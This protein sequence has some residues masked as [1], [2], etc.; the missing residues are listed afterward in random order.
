MRVYSNSNVS[1]TFLL[2]ESKYSFVL[3]KGVTICMYI[4]AI[5]LIELSLHNFWY[6]VCMETTTTTYS[7]TQLI[8]LNRKL[9][10]YAQN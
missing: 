5:V 3:K 2:L 1:S 6:D 9:N 7:N 10:E 8:Q 4:I